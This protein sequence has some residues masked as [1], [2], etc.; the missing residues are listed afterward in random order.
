ML[1]QLYGTL[2][3]ES[4]VHQIDVALPD[5]AT[6]DSV[7]A[8]ALTHQPQAAAVLLDSARRLRQDLMIL[9]N[10]RD[11]RWLQGMDTLVTASDRLDLFV[12]SGAQRAFAF[13]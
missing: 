9:R 5:T 6:I 12:R 2:R 11:I 8:A 1:V 10:G 4:G 3:G 13:D 7:L